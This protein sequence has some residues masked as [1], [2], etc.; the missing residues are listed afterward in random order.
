M[1][2]LTKHAS[3][4]KFEKK[5][6]KLTHSKHLQNVGKS[7]IMSIIFFL[8]LLAGMTIQRIKSNK[9]C[10]KERL[11]RRLTYFRKEF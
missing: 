10:A 8:T 5:K 4:S 2:Y 1:S 11:L 6:L 9:S 3:G 7:S